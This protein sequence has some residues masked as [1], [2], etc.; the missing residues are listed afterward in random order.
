MGTKRAKR[1]AQLANKAGDVSAHKKARAVRPLW[2]T[3]SKKPRPILV[4]ALVGREGTMCG[5]GTSRPA[6]ITHRH[7]DVTC[8]RCKRQ[9]EALDAVRPEEGWKS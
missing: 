9:L 6:F 3:T 2:K 5:S 4:H 7:E 1:R 8:P